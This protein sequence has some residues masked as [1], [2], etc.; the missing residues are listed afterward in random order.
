MCPSKKTPYTFAT[1]GENYRARA[2][3]AEQLDAL[4]RQ[5]A[6]K[7]VSAIK[8][9]FE[10]QESASLEND[11]VLRSQIQAHE[12]SKKK[13]LAQRKN[14]VASHIASLRRTENQLLQLEAQLPGFTKDAHYSDYQQTKQAANHQLNTLELSLLENPPPK[15]DSIQRSI[16]TI[17]QSTEICYALLRQFLGQLAQQSPVQQALNLN[18]QGAHIKHSSRAKIQTLIVQTEQG[19][20]AVIEEIKKTGTLEA[21]IKE[22]NE[23]LLEKEQ[24]VAALEKEVAQY[25]AFEKERGRKAAAKA[26]AEEKEDPQAIAQL[27]TLVA[28]GEQDQAEALIKQNPT[29]LVHKAMVTDLS[30][31]IFNNIT[32]FQSLRAKES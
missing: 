19:A 20:Q 21:K 26:L 29:L 16:V 14:L 25:A 31:R 27:L 30:K 5:G 13:L 15:R 4:K 1:A 10:N 18:L 32:A 17:W 24:H 2:E 9:Q 7:G 28:E 22:K 12:R 6:V 3:E 23:A 11:R 8:A